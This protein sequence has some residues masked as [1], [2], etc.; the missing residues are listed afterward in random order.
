MNSPGSTAGGVRDPSSASSSK[1]RK[2]ST[3]VV[4]S[5][6][7]TLIYINLLSPFLE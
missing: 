1:L 7:F 3:T 5:N 4:S 6:V 2:V